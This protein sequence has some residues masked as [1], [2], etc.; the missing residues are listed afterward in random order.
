MINIKNKFNKEQISTLADIGIKLDNEK[1]YSDDELMDIHDKIT[2][3]Y[4]SNGFDKD[5]N[6]TEIAYK[7]ESLIDLFNDE[8]NI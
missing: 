5:S 6:P 1:N 7:C 2:D 4:L 8:L 3:Y